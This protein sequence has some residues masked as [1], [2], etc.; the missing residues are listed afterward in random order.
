[1]NAQDYQHG[2]HHAYD[3]SDFRDGGGN[4]GRLRDPHATSDERTVAMFEHLTFFTWFLGIPL[5]VTLILWLVKKNESPFIDDHGRESMNMQLS[6]LVYS[7]LTG[8]LGF[9]TCGMAWALWGVI[10]VAA[11]VFGVLASTS[12]NRGEYYRYPAVIRFL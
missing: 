5:V 12:A 10:I 1:M 3:P 7:V 11:V 2:S 4:G 6:L 9:V 8:V